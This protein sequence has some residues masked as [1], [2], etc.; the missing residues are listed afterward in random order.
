VQGKTLSLISSALTWLLNHDNEAA[1]GET[2]HAAHACPVA[3]TEQSDWLTSHDEEVAA[4]IKRE[5]QAQRRLA[6]QQ[7]ERHL[8]ED[9]PGRGA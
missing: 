1:V 2:G 9:T 8:A 6:L 3:T 7:L 4:R 5:T